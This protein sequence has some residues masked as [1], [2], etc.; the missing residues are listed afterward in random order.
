MRIHANAN[1]LST[2][3]EVFDR[4][5]YSDFEREQVVRVPDGNP[6]AF[7]VLLK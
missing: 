3:S 4:M 1:V 7:R 5:F 6:E 2:A